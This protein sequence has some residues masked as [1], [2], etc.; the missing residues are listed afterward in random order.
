MFDEIKNI[1]KGR[2]VEICSL[3]IAICA[4]FLTIQQA[5]TTAYHNKL[6]LIPM[7]QFSIEHSDGKYIEIALENVGTGPAIID[8]FELASV[9]IES[10]KET[11]NDFAKLND[12]NVEGI[13]VLITKIENRTFLRAGQSLPLL[14]ILEPK[15]KNREYNGLSYYTS[16]LPLTVCYRS[17]YQDE[18]NVTTDSN[19]VNEKSC[20]NEGAF[21]F[22]DK[23][24]KF[25]IPF[26]NQVIQSEVFNK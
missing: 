24:V 5:R 1:F 18:F 17:L 6:S 22:F 20:A 13:D 12:L 16:I 8:S 26:G 10:L 3:V 21:K 9:R 11:I 14:K 23:W 15:T 7:L 2:I 19:Y 25:R 4:L